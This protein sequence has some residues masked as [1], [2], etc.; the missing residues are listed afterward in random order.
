MKKVL[1]VGGGSKNIPIPPLYSGWEHV[2]LDIDPDLPRFF[3]PFI[4]GK[5]LRLQRT[6]RPMI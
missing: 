6:C 2:L 4:L 5:W 1:N 3:V